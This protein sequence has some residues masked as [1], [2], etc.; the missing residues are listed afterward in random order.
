MTNGMCT[1]EGREC[2]RITQWMDE[3]EYAEDR[4][5]NE[6]VYVISEWEIVHANTTQDDEGTST[7]ELGDVR[8]MN[9]KTDNVNSQ[10]LMNVPDV[11]WKFNVRRMITEWKP[12]VN[13]REM[14]QIR[15]LMSLEKNS[16]D[17]KLNIS[18]KF[19]SSV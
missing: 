7:Q 13:L 1:K 9:V 3:K 10:L 15:R 5:S 12:I 19:N 14:S 16:D 4:M 11:L 8:E 17:E 6:C 2:T 18:R